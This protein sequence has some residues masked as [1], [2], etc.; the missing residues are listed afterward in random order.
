MHLGYDCP[1]VLLEKADVIV[2]FDTKVPWS[3]QHM[4]SRAAM[5]VS[6]TSGRIR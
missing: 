6:S 1:R 4:R 3:P 5:R 2:I